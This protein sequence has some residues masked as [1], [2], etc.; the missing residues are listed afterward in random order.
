MIW[1]RRG[2]LAV[3]YNSNPR[4]VVTPMLILL[5]VFGGGIGYIWYQ[6]FSPLFDDPHD[7]AQRERDYRSSIHE[8]L[9]GAAA[10][11]SLDPDLKPWP[12]ALTSLDS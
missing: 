7:W 11:T 12:S 4:R 10:Q 3:T 2:S 1:R 9:K 5:L 6:V 8:I